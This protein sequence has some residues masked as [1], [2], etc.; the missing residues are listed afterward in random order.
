MKVG[1]T[2]IASFPFIDIN[3][4]RAVLC[5]FKSAEPLSVHTRHCRKAASVNACIF[6]LR[7]QYELLL[8]R[9]NGNKRTHSDVRHAN[10]RASRLRAIYSGL[11]FFIG[12]RVDNALGKGSRVRSHRDLTLDSSIPLQTILPMSDER[13]LLDDRHLKTHHALKRS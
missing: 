3:R 8:S 5:P 7:Y 4:G 10:T 2:F 11:V 1:D 6:S 9:D 12:E 13:L